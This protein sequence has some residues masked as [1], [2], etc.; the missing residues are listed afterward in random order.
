[1]LQIDQTRQNDIVERLIESRSFKNNRVTWSV[2]YVTSIVSV[3]AFCILCALSAW[4]V[5]LGQQASEM[6]SDIREITPEV[7]KSLELLRYMCKHEN[8]TRKWGECP[9]N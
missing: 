1:M 4:A 9:W 8:F 6:L 3:V 2:F 7:R 5:H